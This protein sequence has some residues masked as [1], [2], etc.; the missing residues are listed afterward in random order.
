MSEVEAMGKREVSVGAATI[1]LGFLLF[2]LGARSHVGAQT[3]TQEI[4]RR[5]LEHAE[6][7]LQALVFAEFEEIEKYGTELDRL[8]ELQ[9]W[10][11]LPTPEYAEFSQKFRKAAQAA[12][13]GGKSGNLEAAAEAYGSMIRECVGC[14]EYM[15]RVRG[16]PRSEAGTDSGE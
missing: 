16:A 8:A 15:R 9:M 2:E 1:L 12:A 7:L 5:K 3:S 11:V 4:M 10:F 6:H 13:L 14:H